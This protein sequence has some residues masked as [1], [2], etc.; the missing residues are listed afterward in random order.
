MIN[1]ENYP[2]I[3]GLAVFIVFCTSF[4]SSMLRESIVGGVFD[5]Y[6]I[7]EVLKN[8]SNNDTLFR[9][10]IVVEVFTSIFIVILAIMFF[11]VLKNE[12]KLL[13]YIALGWWLVEAVLLA[14]SQVAFLALIS[15]SQEYIDAGSPPNSFYITLGNFLY[16][17][18]YDKMFLIHNIFFG[19]G[20]IIWYYLLAKSKSVPKALAWYGVISVLLFI[21]NI[22][23]LMLEPNRISDLNII[24]S[25]PYFPYE[26]VLGLWLLIKGIPNFP[27]K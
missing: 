1:E 25:L 3:L 27:D 9:I 18:F 23:R 17:G 5:P 6:P 11:L 26:I 22:F 20:G 15:L 4:G 2:K 13:A 10:S 14:I 12:N 19:L 21:I 16:L 24:F 8:I 7:A